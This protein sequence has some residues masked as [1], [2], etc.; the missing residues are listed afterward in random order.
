VQDVA[1]GIG[2]DNRI[3]EVPPR[4][5]GLWRLLLSQGHAGALLKT[6]EDYAGADRIVEPSSRSTTPQAAW[7]RV[8]GCASAARVA[9]KRI[10]VLGLTFKPNTDDMRD[11]PLSGLECAKDAYQ[12]ADG[13]DALVIVTEWDEFRGL[14]LDKL[15]ESMRGR[16]LVDLRNVYDPEEAE[17]AGLEYRGIGRLS[18]RP[19][20][21]RRAAE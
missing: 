2:L 10:G 11:A 7:P 4:R 20:P 5:P 14:D 19:A 13:A 3:G 6:A 8:I 1:R 15:A 16:A 9:G 21:V 12:V 18:R 17:R